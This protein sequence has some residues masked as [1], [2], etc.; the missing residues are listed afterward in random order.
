MW[1]EE[2]VEGIG[3]VIRWDMGN[4]FRERKPGKRGPGEALRVGRE[5]RR[6]ERM[7]QLG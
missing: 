5:E 1:M 6:E 2:R 4:G 3:R 7:R